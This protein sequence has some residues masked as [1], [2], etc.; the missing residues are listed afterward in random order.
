MTPLL[1]ALAL[2]A[3]QTPA[4]QD[5]DENARAARCQA[6]IRRN[7]AAALAGANQWQAA[8]GGLAARQCAGLAYVAMG[9]WPAAAGLFEQAAQEAE[10]ARDARSADFWV[11]AGNA[12]LADGEA[13]RAVTAFDAALRPGRA[14]ADP[15]RGEVRL[16]RARAQV[17]L[18]QLP[19]ARA[20]LDEALRLVALD[21]LA[22][23]LSAALARRQGD[24]ARA[25]ADISRA[26]TLAPEDPDILLEAGTIA[27]RSGD[28][29]EAE[30]LYREV[31]RRAPDSEAGRAAAASLP[32]EPEA[33]MAAP[34]APAGAPTPP[35]PAPRDRQQGEPVPAPRL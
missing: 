2:Q 25:G 14:L 5:R 6:D 17:A 23:Y 9:Q 24:L 12:W 10:R 35:P 30:R 16:D 8:G 4:V 21:P 20:D 15:L 1:L 18:N 26:R 22:W 27:G 31:V 29:A 34:A 32:T 33:A 11:Q 13:A 7:A 3:A 28:M 19:A